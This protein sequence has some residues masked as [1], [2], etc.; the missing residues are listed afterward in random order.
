MVNAT[1]QEDKPNIYA[2]T[3]IVLRLD[4]QRNAKK[5]ESLP[6]PSW[7]QSLWKNGPTVKTPHLGWKCSASF[8]KP[9]FLD[10]MIGALVTW[11]VGGSPTP[12]WGCLTNSGIQ[13]V[14]TKNSSLWVRCISSKPTY[15]SCFCWWVPCA[16]LCGAPEGDLNSKP[17]FKDSPLTGVTGATGIEAK[18]VATF[19]TAFV[20]ISNENPAKY[21]ESLSCETENYKP[22]TKSRSL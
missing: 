10:W 21:S 22:T 12:S 17:S 3:K 5:N 9:P 16:L 2:G 15:L 14:S 19:F 11:M 1:G 18:C 7:Q 6:H 4:P 8:P 20:G 13:L